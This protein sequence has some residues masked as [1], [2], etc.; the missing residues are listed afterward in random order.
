L[1]THIIVRVCGIIF[2]NLVLLLSCVP[3]AQPVLAVDALA[4]EKINN[5]YQWANGTPTKDPEWKHGNLNASNS[6]YYEGDSVPYYAHLSGLNIGEIYYVSIEWDTTKSGKHAIDYITTYDRSYTPDDPCVHAGL[7]TDLSPDTE[8]IPLDTNIPTDPDWMGTQEAGDLTIFRGTFTDATGD[9]SGDA[10][11]GYTLTGSYTGDSSTSITFYFRA[12]ESDLVIAW[13]GHIGA[14]ADWG[15]GNSAISISGSPYHMRILDFHN[16]SQDNHLNP[17]NFDRSMSAATVPQNPAIAI[18]KTVDPTIVSSPQSAT[19]TYEVTNEGNVSL[20]GVTVTDDNATPGN[21]GDDFNPAY[22]SG[23]SDGDGELDV[24]ETWI[25]EATREITQDDIDNG[26]PITNWATADS[27]ESDP[28][29]DDATVTVTQTPAIAIVKTVDP[30]IVSSPQSATYTYEVTNEGNVSLTGV[31]VTDDNATPGNTGDDFNPAYFSG[32][33]GDDELDVGETWTYTASRN[34]TQGDIDDGS[35]ITNWATADSNESEPDA[36]DATVTITE[37]PTPIIAIVKTVDPTIVSSPQS[38][39]YTYEVTN[40]GNMSLTGVT[41]TDDNATPGDTGDDFN[42][43]YVSGDDGD[44]ELDVGETWTYT[45]S[46]NITQDDIDDGSPITNWATADSNESEPD[47]D[48]ATIT[49][50]IVE[51]EYDYGD[52]VE[53]TYPTTT[54]NNGAAH[55]IVPG[56]SLGNT[57]DADADGQPSDSA[58]GDDNDGSDDEDGVKIPILIAGEQAVFHV[59]VSGQA[60]VVEAWIDFDGDGIWQ[61]PEEQIFS[62]LLDVGTHSL[63]LMIPGDAVIGTTYARFRLSSQGGLTPSGLAPDGEVEDYTVVIRDIY[64]VPTMTWWS[65]LVTAILFVIFIPIAAHRHLRK[66]T[67]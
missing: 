40:E 34:I 4:I 6:V 25:Y 62:Q 64:E 50:L 45:A 29:S 61:N 17:G 36:D 15:V 8:S 38:A 39:T 7:L 9:P 14:Q 26:S 53:P 5:L 49:I 33:D 55:I 37:E 23:D 3:V 57:V 13:G 42:P 41:V 32:D 22:L 44:D 20:T 19:Y 1:F 63:V 51:D 52:A 28:D 46:R 18:V 10:T 67:A 35:P 43:T 16:V 11:T 59:T 54:I 2:L 12:D 27:N 60:G 66:N 48:D 65:K 56:F 47:A 30:T 31:T 24:D 21:T 58:L